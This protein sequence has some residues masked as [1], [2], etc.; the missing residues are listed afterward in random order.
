MLATCSTLLAKL[1]TVF[2]VMFTSSSINMLVV[3]PHKST[4]KTR[5]KAHAI[6]HSSH[7]SIFLRRRLLRKFVKLAA[8]DRGRDFF[9]ATGRLHD[10]AVI[11]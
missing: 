11:V 9:V 8:F 1:I 2:S 5:I 6:S 3:E 10:G 4:T 7:F